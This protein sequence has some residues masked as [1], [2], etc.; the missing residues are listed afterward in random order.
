LAVFLNQ[1]NCDRNTLLRNFEW[2][3]RLLHASQ[4]S[5]PCRKIKIY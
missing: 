4:C 1:A 2:K 3:G 5:K